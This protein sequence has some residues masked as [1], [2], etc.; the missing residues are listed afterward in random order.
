MLQSRQRG[1]SGAAAPSA[2]DTA[3]AEATVAANALVE[4]I[5]HGS[6]LRTLV[7]GGSLGAMPRASAAAI[8]KACRDK[9]VRLEGVED[10][11]DEG[12]AAANGS[13][14]DSDGGD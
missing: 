2:A 3:A 8:A 13:A 10:E 6:V 1:R 11:Q 7:L 14:S 4:A 5:K 9:G 12:A